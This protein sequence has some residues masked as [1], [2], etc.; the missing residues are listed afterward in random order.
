MPSVGARITSQQLVAY[1]VHTSVDGETW[2]LIKKGTTT[3]AGA[4]DGTTLID[5][6]NGSGGSDTY[7][8]YW[9]R[10][11]SGALKGAF[12]MVV[13]DNGSGTLTLENAGFSAQVG[14]GVAYAIYKSPLPMVVVDSSSGET[15]MVD[16]GR[17]EAND[18][19]NTYWVLP[20]TGNRRGRAAKV[21]DF[22]SSTGTFTLA[23]GLG[24]AL[25]AGDVVLLLKA[26]EVGGLQMQLGEPYEA[27]PSARVNFSRGDG[28]VM[29]R[30]GSVNFSTDILASGTLQ[31]T[32]NS[33]A[34]PSVLAGLFQATGL[35][36]VIGKTLAV[37]TGSTTT[38]VK[39]STATHENVD[40]G[41]A[42]QWKGNVAFVTAKTDGGGSADTLTVSPALPSAPAA[43]DK[44]HASRM[45]RKTTDGD[46]LG[47]WLLV[48]V[49]GI[50]TLLTGCKGNVQLTSAGKPQFAWQFSVDHWIRQAE[51]VP[52]NLGSAYSTALPVLE[53]DRIAY[54]D[55][56]KID[57]AGFTCSPNVA[58][59]P[60]NVSGRY[61]I[62]G[63]AGHHI[64]GIGP[65]ATFRELLEADGGLTQDELWQARTAKDMK[66][67]MGSHG[68]CAAVRIPV[69]RLVQNPNPEDME[70]MQAAPS[71][72]EAQDADTA[73]N[74]NGTLVKVPDFA[75]HLF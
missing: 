8:G 13:D 56:T 10:I 54:L 41:A 33:D 37:E 31:D 6:N 40:I 49:D 70:G 35:V 3:S 48:E 60:K 74:G 32:A 64:T 42:I 19:W 12:A 9:V 21:S 72:I 38:A 55:T 25:A 39:V 17:A 26:L 58:T 52:A 30:D 15:D 57:I 5:A 50:R 27:R 20:L 34:N 18:F 71:V 47:I 68:D 45:Y 28:V 67:I 23:A 46:L 73:D 22:V 61:G 4:S 53:R 65:T 66:V 62:N 36:E 59:A 7:N 11:L 2:Q 24:G 51:A 14:S 29:G 43:A 75:I 69:G 44:A 63:R 1:G 16:A